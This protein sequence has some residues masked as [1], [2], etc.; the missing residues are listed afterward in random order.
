MNL[1]EVALVCEGGCE[2]T[3]RLGKVKR[4]DEAEIAI[5][6]KKMMRDFEYGE[7]GMVDL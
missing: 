2:L 7:F 6:V 1:T 4:E 3:W 5:D